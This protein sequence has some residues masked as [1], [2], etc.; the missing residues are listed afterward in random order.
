MQIKHIYTQANASAPLVSFII[1]CFNLPAELVKQCLDSILALSLSAAEREIIVVDDGSE[2]CLID[3]LSDYLDDIVYIRQP[4][5]GVS[6]ARNMGINISKG[7]FIQFVDGDDC[8]I[9]KAYEHC[10]DIVRYKNADM[11]LFRLTSSEK[12]LKDA[13]VDITFDVPTSGNEYMM[14]NNLH[15]SPCG[16]I[17]KKKMLVNL[18]FHV[19]VEYGEDEEFTP[20]L[21]LR[22]EHLYST[23]AVAYYYRKR[24]GSAT[25]NRSLR[26]RVKRLHDA[27]DVITTLRNRAD[28]LPYKDRLAIQRRVDQLTM[29]Y[30][31]NVITLTHNGKYLEES[32]ERLRS[33]GLFPLPAHDYTRKYKYFSR[34]VN[35]K[36]G[37][38][39]L[40]AVLPF[41][42]KKR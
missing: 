24:R 6:A 25:N 7:K 12:D 8:I 28:T 16:Y 1:P 15:A 42:K 41:I 4:N 18:L 27:V 29:D 21:V 34:M 11:V 26:S 14:H 37:R 32:V 30:L 13:D 35:S 23:E 33:K 3:Y 19:G 9:P 36:A 20:Q 38:E 40:L 17:F 2:D 39:I 31:Y 22:S 10:L 5:Q